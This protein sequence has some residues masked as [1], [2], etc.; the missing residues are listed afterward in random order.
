MAA[1]IAAAIGG[2]LRPSGV[3]H[4][5]GPNQRPNGRGLRAVLLPGGFLIATTPKRGTAAAAVTYVMAALDRWRE[6]HP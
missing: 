4:A 6:A 5:P 1:E 3:I 2:E